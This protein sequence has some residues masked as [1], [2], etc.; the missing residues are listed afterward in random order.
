MSFSTI[1]RSG[2]DLPTFRVGE[3]SEGWMFGYVDSLRATDACTVSMIVR[4][5]H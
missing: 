5:M 4:G 3:E 2:V 1:E